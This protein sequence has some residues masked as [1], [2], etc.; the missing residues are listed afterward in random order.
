MVKTIGFG[1]IPA[2]VRGNGLSIAFGTISQIADGGSFFI[3]DTAR[4]SKAM[5]NVVL[6]LATALEGSV[7]VT[8]LGSSDGYVSVRLLPAGTPYPVTGTAEADIQYMALTI[9]GSLPA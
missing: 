8:A 7:A 2:V 3:P 4:G 6:C 5:R 1:R 9:P